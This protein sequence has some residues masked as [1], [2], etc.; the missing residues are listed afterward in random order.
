MD[1]EPG[2]KKNL[3]VQKLGGILKLGKTQAVSPGRVAAET[4][5]GLE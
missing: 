5:I 1:L 3:T 4:C 2:K